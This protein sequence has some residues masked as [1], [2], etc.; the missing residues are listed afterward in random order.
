MTELYVHH[1]PVSLHKELEP[2][3]P[4]TGAQ[5]EEL[6]ETQREGQRTLQLRQR[7]HLYGKGNNQEHSSRPNALHTG[8]CSQAILHKQVNHLNGCFGEAK[9]RLREDEANC[10]PKTI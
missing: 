2:H 8:L 6:Q 4:A 10:S 5:E 7:L 3:P 1:N 9:A